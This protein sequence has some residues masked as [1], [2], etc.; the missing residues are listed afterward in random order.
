MH[1]QGHTLSSIGATL[2]ISKERV[3]QIKLQAIGKLGPARRNPLAK[4]KRSKTTCGKSL[5]RV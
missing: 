3:R 5:S 4:R 1:L 2:G